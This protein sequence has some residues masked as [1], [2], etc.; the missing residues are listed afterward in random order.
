MCHRGIYEG[1]QPS[2]SLE[3]FSGES[4]DTER[5]A[6]RGSAVSRTKRSS[7]LLHTRLLLNSFRGLEKALVGQLN[8]FSCALRWK[9]IL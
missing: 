7:K 1:A 3:K 5:T 8:V 6:E 2:Y 4:N 9:S